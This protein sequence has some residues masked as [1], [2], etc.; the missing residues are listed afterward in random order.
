M[1][2]YNGFAC[3]VQGHNHIKADKVC[4]DASGYYADDSMSIIVVADGHGSENYT[5]TD[6]GSKYA[7]EAAIQS[8]KDYIQTINEKQIPF[9]I[10]DNDDDQL[11]EIAKNILKH[12]H[13]SV[14]E[15]VNNR[16]FTESELSTVSE[17][18]RTKYLSGESELIAKAYGTTLIAVCITPEYWFGMHI[19]DGKCVA[20]D[21]SANCLE[22]IPWDDDCQANIT[23]SLC[24]SNA[25]D[26]FRYYKSNEL[27]LAVFIGSDGIDDSYSNDKELY[28]LYRTI[29]MIFAEQG[30]DQCKSEVEAFLPSITKRGSGDDV[31]IG[32]LGTA[33]V[34]VKASEYI[35]AQIECESASDSLDRLEKEC[36]IA[37]EKV[38]YI[39]TT[40]Q[41]M[42]DSLVDSEEKLKKAEAECEQKAIEKAAAK[43]RYDNA[44]NALQVA[45]VAFETDNKTEDNTSN[46]IE[47]LEQ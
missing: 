35:K 40:L 9:N 5:R 36:Q 15:D 23:T 22:P 30:N 24:D 46:N 28:N 19:G 41:K 43:K 44:N 20:I 31:S 11:K 25:I 42:R 18:H 34:S 12:W 3:S 1:S 6:I 13:S 29:F 10:D 2:Q 7:V 4:Q 8:I 37:R 32:C 21:K 17:K 14:D 33:D 27:P 38:D 39:S 16:P 47:P 45:R 26:E